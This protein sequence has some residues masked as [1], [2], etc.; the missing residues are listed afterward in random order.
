ME[1]AAN[2]LIIKIRKNKEVKVV[3]MTQPTQADYVQPHMS[4]HKP[5]RQQD[6]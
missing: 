5:P 3:K 1:G 6:T 4:P 2:D